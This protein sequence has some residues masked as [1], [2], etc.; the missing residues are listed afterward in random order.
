MTINK[1]KVK[2]FIEEHKEDIADFAGLAVAL[3]IGV[4]IGY[5]AGARDAVEGVLEA[6][7]NSGK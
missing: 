7:K 2:A 1:E 4:G 3:I 5:G 6:A